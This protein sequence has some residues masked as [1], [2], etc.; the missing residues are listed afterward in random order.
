[1]QVSKQTLIETGRY[2]GSLSEED[3]ANVKK[4]LCIQLAL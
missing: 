2:L 1:M 4:A 3:L